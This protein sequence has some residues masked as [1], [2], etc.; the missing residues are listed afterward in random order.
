MNMQKMLK[1]MQKVQG[2]MAKMQEELQGTVYEAE[3]GGGLVKVTMNGKYEV[4][5]VRLKK[6]AVDPED[7]E[8]LED[9]LLAAFNEARAKADADSQQRMGG[10]TKGLGLP[11]M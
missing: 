7:V 1:D 9:L 4:Q 6:E 2:R 11:G 8:A 10:L 3:A 5:A